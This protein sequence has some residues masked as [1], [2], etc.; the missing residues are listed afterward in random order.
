MV[1]MVM[2]MVVTVM[3]L[4]MLMFIIVKKRY[5]F[6]FEISDRKNFTFQ[7][8]QEIFEVLR[9]MYGNAAIMPEEILVP[10]WHT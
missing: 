9:S 2:V 1:M 3:M 10:D 6:N 4:L 5:T 8:K 7:Q